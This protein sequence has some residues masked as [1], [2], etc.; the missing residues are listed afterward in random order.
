MDLQKKKV[1]KS[2]NNFM[3]SE[4]SDQNIDYQKKLIEEIE[5]DEK[6]MGAYF[7]ETN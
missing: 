2:F 4:I 1:E 5:K 3:Q 6:Y 7:D